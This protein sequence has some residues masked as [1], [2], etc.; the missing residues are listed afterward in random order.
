M[1]K[2]HDVIMKRTLSSSRGRK[3]STALYGR[4]SSLCPSLNMYFDNC[5][6]GSDLGCISTSSSRSSHRMTLARRRGPYRMRQITEVQL[7][8]RWGRISRPRR[9]LSRLLLPEEVSPTG[10]NIAPLYTP[11]TMYQAWP[12]LYGALVDYVFLDV[13]ASLQWRHNGSDR[14]SNHQP[15]ECLLNR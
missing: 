14:V 2:R 13:L 9:R 7:S 6:M 1:Q 4:V 12:S 8:N 5:S 15:H 3:I 11:Q 10:R